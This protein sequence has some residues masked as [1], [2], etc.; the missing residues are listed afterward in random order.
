[1]VAGAI[2]L[3]VSWAGKAFASVDVKPRF[4]ARSVTFQSANQDSYLA[5][6]KTCHPSDNLVVLLASITL[7][8]GPSSGP[9]DSCR[10][11]KTFRTQSAAN[12]GLGKPFPVGEQAGAGHS[13]DVQGSGADGAGIGQ[14]LT[15][16]GFVHFRRLRPGGG[17]VCGR[18]WA[19]LADR[20]GRRL[21]GA[22]P[23]ERRSSRT[24]P[25]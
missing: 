22:M 5:K 6:G 15:D 17:R 19:R 9:V 13:Q 20:L 23:A 8:R 3:P 1:M 18:F 2:Q 4:D 21:P 10:A 16:Q 14:L 7:W 25:T 24:R 12:V 11:S